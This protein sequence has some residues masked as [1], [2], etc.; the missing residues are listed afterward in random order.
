MG[1]AAAV[2]D[3]ERGNITRNYGVEQSLKDP[4]SGRMTK[5]Q[6]CTGERG[7]SEVCFQIVFPDLVR[8]GGKVGQ[9]RKCLL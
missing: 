2:S 8:P 3:Q 9:R 7:M 6:T 1:A 5:V 4:M